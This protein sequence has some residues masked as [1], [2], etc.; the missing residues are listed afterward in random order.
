MLFRLS[1]FVCIQ[2][3]DLHC[4]C[5]ALLVID[6]I[7]YLALCRSLSS[8]PSNWH[9]E[10]D[11]AGDSP[12]L[13]SVCSKI[14]V[15]HFLVLFSF[16]CYSGP[17]VNMHRRRTD[18]EKSSGQRM[19]ERLAYYSCLAIGKFLCLYEDNSAS[20]RRGLCT[21]REE[22]IK[23]TLGKRLFPPHPSSLCS[24]SSQSLLCLQLAVSCFFVIPTSP[25]NS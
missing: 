24:S 25:S 23:G 16:L 14:S 10:R 7:R 12:L 17:Q 15:M 21:L 9:L 3:G 18:K 20:P 13:A 4:T 6:K 5:I 11:K 2:P 8:E 1:M 22:C 19:A